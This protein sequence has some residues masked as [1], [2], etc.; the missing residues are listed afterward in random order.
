VKLVLK[1]LPGL[2]VKQGRKGRRV[3]RAKKVP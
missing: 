2:L 3:L 1:G